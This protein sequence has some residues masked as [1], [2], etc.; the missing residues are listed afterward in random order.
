MTTWQ[1]IKFDP[2]DARFQ[3]EEF[4]A[5]LNANP[6]L[7]E[8][9]IR[10]FIRPRHQIITSLGLLNAAADTIDRWAPEL[11][12]TGKHACDIVV[13]DSGRCAYTLIEMED[14]NPE[15]IY[16]SSPATPY[17]TNRFNRGYSQIV[18]CRDL[19]RRL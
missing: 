10:D 16:E 13:G 12:L 18:D 2:G 7:A 15:S 9:A 14:A 8:G 5:Y 19:R 1:S 3:L 17:F 4:R 11:D 6:R